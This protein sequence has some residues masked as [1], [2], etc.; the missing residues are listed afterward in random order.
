M[1]NLEKWMIPGRVCSECGRVFLSNRGRKRTCGKACATARNNR[2]NRERYAR[3]PE[4]K[5][6]ANTAWRASEKGKAWAEARNP[7]E[8]RDYMRV[9]MRARRANSEQTEVK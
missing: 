6:Q 1:N 8:R 9:Y 7:A 4:A 5:R 3:N 2:K